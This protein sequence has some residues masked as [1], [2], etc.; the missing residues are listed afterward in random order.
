MLDNAPLIYLI[1]G[2][3]SGELLASRLMTALLHK[4]KG[5]VRFAGVGGNTM[6][7]AGFQT[8][9]DNSELAVMGFAEVLPRIPRILK[10]IN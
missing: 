8:L 3:A 2:E 6:Q 4:T 10:L 5:N 9:Y 1:A 7:Q